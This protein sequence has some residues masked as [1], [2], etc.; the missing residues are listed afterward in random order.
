MLKNKSTQNIR[1]ISRIQDAYAI[2]YFFGFYKF[3]NEKKSLVKLIHRVTFELSK[4]QVH[5]LDFYI[6]IICRKIQTMNAYIY[7]KATHLIIT[8]MIRLKRRDD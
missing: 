1:T 7:I 2:F 6:V 8:N 5:I 4:Y 3:I